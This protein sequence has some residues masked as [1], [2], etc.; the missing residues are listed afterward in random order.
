MKR[1]SY[2]RE[3]VIAAGSELPTRGLLCHDCDEFIPVFEDLSEEDERRVI[4]CMQHGRLIM[5]TIELREATGCSLEW[6]KLWVQHR[7]RP[8]PAKEPTPCPYCGEPLRTS[9]A[10]Q[11]RFC[12]RDWHDEDNVVSLGDKR[13]S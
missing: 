8:E 13:S 12:R 2:T 5:A 6:A 1:N 4:H 9:L 10:K 7:G 3:E 11:C